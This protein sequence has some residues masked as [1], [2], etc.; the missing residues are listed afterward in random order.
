MLGTRLAATAPLIVG[1]EWI[2][3][4]LRWGAEGSMGRP[5]PVPYLTHCA[6]R[7]RSGG[8]QE[9]GSDGCWLIVTGA[10]STERDW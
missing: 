7:D 5:R 8:G 6:L 2:K 9:M 1:C 3:L 4:E 10:T